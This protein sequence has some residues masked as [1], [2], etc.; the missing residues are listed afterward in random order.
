[1]YRDGVVEKVIA[2][3]DVISLHGQNAFVKAI[4]LPQ[5]ELRAAVAGDSIML[6][7]AVD[8]DGDCI[9]DTV[10]L[11]QATAP[12]SSTLNGDD[13]LLFT[14]DRGQYAS[15]VHPTAGN[16]RLVNASP[17]NGWQL[18]SFRP[19]GPSTAIYLSDDQMS[20]GLYSFT[21]TWCKDEEGRV[22][23]AATRPAVCPAD[24]QSLAST[25]PTAPVELDLYLDVPV[26]DFVGVFKDLVDTPTLADLEN[27]EAT[28]AG[29]K[30]SIVV[31]DDGP[32][33]LDADM[34]EAYDP[35][36]AALIAIV[37]PPY[38]PVPVLGQGLWVLLSG[39]VSLFGG[40][41]FWRRRPA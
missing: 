41:A 11:V 15:V 37:L 13:P 40:I 21:A 10:G 31:E 36:G 26:E 6:K 18:N 5:P 39:L 34:G 17:D 4:S 12:S 33:D 23:Q 14:P 2:E 24:S 3:G 38:V 35:F 25:T 28:E 8:T 1:M 30:V 9:E 16:V 20:G 7:M 32:F 22:L 19:L 29:I 27:V